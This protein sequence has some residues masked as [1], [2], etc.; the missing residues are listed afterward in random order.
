MVGV[1]EHVGVGVAVD[2]EQHEQSGEEVGLTGEPSYDLNSKRMDAEQGT[3]CTT[4]GA[5]TQGHECRL[6]NSVVIVPDA[7]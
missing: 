6:P 4:V 3:A 5:H 1:R 7:C 2:T